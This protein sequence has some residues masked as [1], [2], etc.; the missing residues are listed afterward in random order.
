MPFPKCRGPVSLLLAS[1]H[2][3]HTASRQPV[4]PS[5]Q[6]C[7]SVDRHIHFSPCPIVSFPKHMHSLA[8]SLSPPQ[9]D[10]FSFG[11]VLWEIWCLG[12]QPYNNI[13]LAD[14]FAGVMTGTLRPGVPADCDPDWAS[15]MQVG[16]GTGCACRGA[17]GGG[18]GGCRV[19]EGD[20]RRA[21]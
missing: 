3:A 8:L 19:C 1:K 21:G 7:G 16:A 14:I 10:V 20:L 9:V 15:L 12:E 5:L 11:I 18:L 13:S 17:E 4:A 2:V 6:P